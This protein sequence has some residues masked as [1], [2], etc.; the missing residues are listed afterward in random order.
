MGLQKPARDM[1]IEAARWFNYRFPWHQL[2]PSLAQRV[3]SRLDSSQG[4]RVYENIQ[5]GLRMLLDLSI[6]FERDIYLNASSNMEMLSVFHKVLRP[7]DVFIDGGANIG[8]LS[9]VAWQ[10]VGAKGRVYAF[11]PQP[12]AL[13]LLQRNIELNHANN[14]S[15]VA[16]AAWHEPGFATFYEFADSDH[17]LPSLGARPDKN[18]QREYQVETVRMDDVVREPVRLYKLDIEGAEWGAMRGSERILF[19]DP[20]PHVIIE[21]NPRTCE[22][23]GHHPLQVLDWFFERGSHRRMHLIRRRRCQRVNRK[24]LADLFERQQ[25]KSHNVWLAPG[26][27]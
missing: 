22:G 11:E 17:D 20:P 5:G 9:L 12:T 2:K 18:V 15:V 23:F 13:R 27:G 6:A 10:C 3:R 21:L 14:I 1:V 8:F 25:N 4:R 26:T 24:F 16:K 19:S 7:G